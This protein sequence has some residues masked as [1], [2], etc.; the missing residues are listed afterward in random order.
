MLYHLEMSAFESNSK[1]FKNRTKQSLLL[2]IALFCLLLL[3]KGFF[4]PESIKNRFASATEAIGLSDKSSNHSPENAT[5]SAFDPK[6]ILTGR[7]SDP[8]ISSMSYLAAYLSADKK[9]KIIL[10]EKNPGDLLPM[11]SVTKL[12]TAIVA[13]RNFTDDETFTMPKGVFS[14]EG[15]SKRFLP[16]SVF[17]TKEL[18]RALL[19]ES[20]NDAAAAFADKIGQYDF[21]GKM[22]DEAKRL[23]MIDTRYDNA[24]GLDPKNKKEIINYSTA[25][26]LLTLTEEIIKNH[27]ELL[28]LSSLS[29]YAIK[30]VSGGFNHAAISTNKF[31]REEELSCQNEPLKIL[32]GKTGYTDL[33]KKN[34]ILI[35][36][37]PNKEGY[38]ITIVLSAD[39]NFP[40]TQKLINWVCEAYAWPERN[41]SE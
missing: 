23:G 16:G 2:I 4:S 17:T 8:A 6:P 20:N 24:T 18:L 35:T 39:D 30:N 33:A 37:T 3:M 12:M 11:A 31:L 32:G 34:L 9:E 14:W 38:L 21:I 40:E 36:E 5:V 13:A 25:R 15:S 19:I 29:E 10:A 26:N 41:Y 27:P 22:N 7:E 1:P 28:D